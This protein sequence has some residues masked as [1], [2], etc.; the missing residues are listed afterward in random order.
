MSSSS[1]KII[2][3]IG[4]TGAQG[5]AVIDELLKLAAD[6][7]SSPYVVR[8]LTRDLSSKRAQALAAK[9]VQLFQGECE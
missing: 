3:I 1:N 7:T 9:G 5:T 4:A 8:A 6:G 2:L